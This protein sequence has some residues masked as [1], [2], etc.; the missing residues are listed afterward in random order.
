MTEQT[1]STSTTVEQLAD[2]ALQLADGGRAILGIAGPPG[3]GKSTL[4]TALAAALGPEQA[5]VVGMDAFHLSNRELDRLGRRER[6]G[7]PDTFD[8]HG[9]LALLQRLRWQ[10]EDVVYAPVFDRSLEE[11][12]TGAVPVAAAVPLVITEGNYLL[13]QS[14]TWS[15]IHRHLDACWFLDVPE[16]TLFGRLLTRHM[17]F[18][19]T[20]AEAARWVN[21][22]D[23][24][25]ARLVAGTRGAADW[26]VPPIVSR[27]PPPAVAAN[28]ASPASAPHHHPPG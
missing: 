10:G 28:G 6:K 18:G 20:R 5:V 1:A 22:N 8:V 15:Q 19:R 17:T 13:L 12:V 25:N 16:S 14:E 2:K 9:Y 7:A 26:V 3:A 21:G 24:V 4:A 23:V 11:P 27:F